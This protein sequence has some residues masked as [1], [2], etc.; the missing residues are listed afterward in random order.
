MTVARLLGENVVLFLLGL[1]LLPIIG[2]AR[3]VQ[4]IRHRWGLA[5]LTGIAAAGIV[6]ATLAVLEVP[7]SPGALIAVTIL[8]LA[9]GYGRLRPDGG[10]LERPR[11]TTADRIAG[12]V[13]VAV[14]LACAAGMAY[15]VASEPLDEYDGWAIWGLKAHAIAALGGSSGDVLASPAYDFSHLEYPLL[16]PG[17]EA[18]GLNSAGRYESRLIVIQCV[19]IGLAGLLAV[20]GALRDRVRPLLLWPALAAIAV[21]PAMLSQ[22]ES[23]LADM[24]LALFVAAG[25]VTAGRW[26]LEPQDSW[27]ALATLFFAAA[28]L[29]KD[30]GD[31]FVAAALT[32]LVLVAQGRRLQVGIAT[33]AVGL[34]VL[35]WRVYVAVHHFSTSDFKLSR[36]FDPGW[37]GH[38]LGHAPT[39]FAILLSHSVDIHYYEFLLPLGLGAIALSLTRGPRTLGIFAAVF[40]AL[41]AVGLSW[42]YVIS[43]IPLLEYLEITEDRVTASIVI[44]C[45]ALAP[46]LVAEA[47]R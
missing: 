12:R 31:L 26:L 3:T 9:G 33:A 28:A 2:L 6:A 11:R 38:H 37:L 23:G 24:P 39:A 34:A 16:A 46:L 44:G 1:G 36:S 17:L 5:Y 35:P 47:T 22:L 30:E 10:R 29:T 42:I 18:L 20:W 15:A 4:Q 27:L 32:G 7:F 43:Q 41:S 14:L 45:A 8:A 40:V 21:A 25:L 13:G 19:L